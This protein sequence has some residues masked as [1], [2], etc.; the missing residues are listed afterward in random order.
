MWEIHYQVATNFIGNCYVLLYIVGIVRYNSPLQGK[1]IVRNIENMNNYIH[2][3]VKL[4][5]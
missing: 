5:N 3:C 2:L 1:T 4:L